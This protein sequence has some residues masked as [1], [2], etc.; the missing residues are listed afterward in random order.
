VTDPRTPFVAS[1]PSTQ[2]EGRAALHALPR[3][4]AFA[5]AILPLAV[6]VA[7]SASW[8]QWDLAPAPVTLAQAPASAH[9]LHA[10]ALQLASGVCSASHPGRK[11]PSTLGLA[12]TLGLLR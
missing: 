5:A 10:S 12:P 2:G 3:A 6:A 9:H 11:A 1:N 7:L 8:S 4:L